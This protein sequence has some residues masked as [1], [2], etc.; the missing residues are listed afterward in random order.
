M[1]TQTIG[2]NW[3]TRSGLDRRRC[4]VAIH[5]PERRRRVERRGGHDRRRLFYLYRRTELD[6]R[7]AYRALD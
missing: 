5:F 3:G 4:K 6:L 7:G 2:D 1:E